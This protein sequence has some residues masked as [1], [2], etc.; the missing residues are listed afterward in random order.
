MSLLEQGKIKI[1]NIEKDDVPHA[2]KLLNTL[3]KFETSN[4]YKKLWN[5]FYIQS[6]VHSIVATINHLVIGYGSIVVETKIHGRKIGHIED[7]ISH[8]DYR[9]KGVG[10]NI[11]NKL[12]EIAKKRGCYKIVLHCQQK[13]KLFYNKCDY[14]INGLAMERYI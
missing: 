4:D 9:N 5:D 6:N 8:F 3:S 7:I 12:F 2:V 11:V 14:K 10:K 1:R 13:N